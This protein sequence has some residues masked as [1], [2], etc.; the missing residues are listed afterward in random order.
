MAR[1]V[2]KDS[3]DQAEAWKACSSLCRC[4]F[5]TSYVRTSAFRRECRASRPLY[6]IFRSIHYSRIPSWHQS[7][8]HHSA[9]RGSTQFQ[10][11]PLS[12]QAAGGRD[13]PPPVLTDPAFREA[14][15]AQSG[16]A[17]LLGRRL[18]RFESQKARDPLCDKNVDR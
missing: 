10:S 11:D 18:E 12:C 2:S 15:L 8:W 16:E 9:D 3:I 6:G 17:R 14:V 5:W 4:F 1:V 13:A 7:D